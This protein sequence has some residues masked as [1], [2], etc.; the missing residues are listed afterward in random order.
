MDASV[1]LHP[2]AGGAHRLRGNYRKPQRLRSKADGS[3]FSL[4]LA[5]KLVI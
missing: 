2:G 4:D 3:G 1:G 5:L